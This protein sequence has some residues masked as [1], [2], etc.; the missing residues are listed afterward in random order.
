MTHLEKVFLPFGNKFI[1]QQS[2]GHKITS[3]VNFLTKLILSKN[4]N[5]RKRALELGCGCGIVSILLKHRRANWDI[6]AIDIQSNLVKLSQNNSLLADVKIE[7]RCE[8]IRN[9]SSSGSFD[10]IFSNPPYFPINIGKLSP[11]KTRAI[12][13]SEVCLKMDDALGCV[14]RNISTIGVAFIMY[15][16]SRLDE[17]KKNCLSNDLFVMSI[18]RRVKSFVG[19]V[20][21]A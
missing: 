11:N 1:F 2:S 15:P 14:K 13:R 17:F 3:D 8:D 6:V 20:R 9:F 10:L 16:T 7:F 19:V 21:L 5:R 12:A 4:T 18:A